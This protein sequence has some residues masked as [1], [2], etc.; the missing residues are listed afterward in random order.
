MTKTTAQHTAIR[1]VPITETDCSICFDI[2]HIGDREWNPTSITDHR[3][4]FWFPLSQVSYIKRTPAGSTEHDILHVSNWILR[5]K[6][7]IS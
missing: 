4:E 6:G 1:G 3:S 2:F 7:I 5:Q